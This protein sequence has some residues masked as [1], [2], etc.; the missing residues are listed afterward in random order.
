[1][2][3]TVHRP[4]SAGQLP[5][6]HEPLTNIGGGGGGVPSAAS[7]ATTPSSDFA[8]TVATVG[9]DTM[10]GNGSPRTTEE[11]ASSGANGETAEGTDEQG[12][13]AIHPQDG[14]VNATALN[15]S[16]VNLSQGNNS[17]AGTVRGSGLLPSLLLLLGLWG[18][19]AL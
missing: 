15:S 17:D 3:E 13:E 6:E 12:E 18:L 4:N 16:L 10:L 5:S 14:E 8:Q 7:T 2:E 19:E 11:S 9:G 1:M